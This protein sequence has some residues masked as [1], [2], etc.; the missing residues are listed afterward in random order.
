MSD[1]LDYFRIT[2]SD[3]AMKANWPRCANC[4]QQFPD[5]EDFQIV[6]Y[7]TFLPFGG[8]TMIEHR[9]CNECAIP[10]TVYYMESASTFSATT[11]EQ[12]EMV[13]G[14]GPTYEAA[15]MDLRERFA[16]RFNRDIV[17]FVRG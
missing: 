1:L 12:N 4:D 10:R 3:D 17:N 9:V 14:F 5:E 16:E 15:E 2:F 11:Y 6:I 7:P 8:H 13:I